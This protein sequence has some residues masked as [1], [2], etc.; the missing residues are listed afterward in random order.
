[1]KEIIS[2]AAI[3]AIILAIAAI[4]IY[5]MISCGPTKEV[6]EEQ[7]LRKE[8]EQV[9]KERDLLSDAIRCHIDATNGDCDILIDVRHFLQINNESLVEFD[10]WSYCY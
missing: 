8:L 3:T 9:T 4:G 2:Q 6:T 7:R 1:M 5:A 10:K